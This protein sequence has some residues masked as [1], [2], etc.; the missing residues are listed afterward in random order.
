VVSAVFLDEASPDGVFSPDESVLLRLDRPLPSEVSPE[1][2]R[3]RLDPPAECGTSVEAT[4]DPQVLRVRILWGTPE[5]SLAGVHGS[6][7][8]ATGL[9]VELGVG[10]RQ[11]VDLQAVDSL[12]VLQRVIWED[13]GDPHGNLVVDG[14]DRLRLLFDRPVALDVTGE[15]DRR[16]RS[17]QDVILSKANDRLDDGKTPALWEAGETESEIGIVLGSRPVLTVAGTLEREATIERFEAAAPSGLA[18]NGTRVLPCSRIR[19]ARGGRGA[20]SLQETDIEYS[21][22]VPAPRARL[23][24]EFPPPGN[25]IY[26]TLSPTLG[27]QALVVGGATAD[28]VRRPLDQVLLL[29]PFS[30]PVSDRVTLELVSSRLPEPTYH[31]TATTLPGSDGWVGTSDDLLV[32]AGGTDGRR[33]LGALSVVRIGASGAFEVVALPAELRVPRWEHAAVALPGNRLLIDG[34]RTQGR[35]FQTGLVGCG[36]VLTFDVEADPPA[37]LAHSAFR[38]V[39]RM[40]H[41]MTLVAAPEDGPTHV[42]VYGGYGRPRRRPVPPLPLGLRIDGVPASDVFFPT[43]EGAVLSWPVLL[44]PNAPDR[45]VWEIP[46]DFSF[47]LL[48]WGHVAVAVPSLDPDPGT[49]RKLTGTGVV[50]LAGGTIGHYVRGLDRD[51]NLWEMPL[52]LLPDLPQ[53]HE[54]ANALLFRYNPDTPELSTL[55]V[56]QHPYPDPARAA[57]RIELA[58]VRVPEWG[59]LL[60]GGELPR[61][62]GDVVPFATAEVLLEDPERLAEVSVRL[63]TARTRHQVHYV[64][65]GGMRSVLLVGGMPSS[66]DATRFSAVEEIPLP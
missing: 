59:V 53:G 8:G 66:D 46:C 39:P 54:S 2:I 55:E 49:S 47:P 12:P 25:R 40:R 61:S 14:G 22:N 11:S 5:L 18:L 10:G 65:V 7:R 35:D 42:L 15:E 27:G 60:T 63:V 28:G 52:E 19:D 62:F 26:H 56:L 36:E 21:S 9:I 6:D 37:I 44:D 43:D 51:A 24:A 58:A 23:E 64:G 45:S 57:E 50:L 34:G 4:E 30:G 16:V 20:I 33:A 3:V 32:I 38:S 1:S 17:P 41:S 29:N 13:S 31:H 48:R